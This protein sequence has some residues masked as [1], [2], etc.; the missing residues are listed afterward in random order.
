MVNSNIMIGKLKQKNK[1]SLAIAAMSAAGFLICSYLTAVYYL[2]DGAGAYCGT[3]W[4]CDAV[5]NSRFSKLFGIPAS[6]VGAVGYALVIVA[7]ATSG[8]ERKRSLIIGLASAGVGLS[9]YLSWAEFFVIKQTCP[10]CVASALIILAIW[11]A[12]V[13]GATFSQV[14]AGVV[15]A[16]AAAVGGY[17]S[18]VLTEPVTVQ[19]HTHYRAGLQKNLAGHL[20][21][22]GAVMYGS[23]TCPACTTQKS[24]FGK[25]AKNLKYVECNPKGKNADPELCE[26]KEITRYPTWEIDGSFYKGVMTLDKLSELSGYKNEPGKQ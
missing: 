2:T 11:I 7:S 22:K 4:E 24:I 10:F 19:T 23:F 21:E 1:I 20:T 12:A 13:W 17:S 18:A 9:I 6:L 3:G 16:V 5:L 14:A 8:I 15:I 26:E 25:Y